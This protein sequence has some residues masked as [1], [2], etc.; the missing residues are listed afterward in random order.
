MLL[1]LP[2]EILLRILSCFSA[3][4]LACT[5]VC[6][7][8]LQA[9]LVPALMQEQRRLGLSLPLSRG[10]FDSATR[11]LRFLKRLASRRPQKLSCGAASSLCV[12]SAH[13]DK[14]EK[15]LV[16]PPGDDDG[17][18]TEDEADAV[19]LA[20]GS[21]SSGEPTA[22]LPSP[23][24]GLSADMV[25]REVAAG[26]SHCLLLTSDGAVLSWGLDNACGQCG[27]GNTTAL[28]TPTP[29]EALRGERIMQVACG[30]E[31]SLVLTSTGVVKSFGGGSLGRLGLGGTDDV[32]TPL[33]VQHTCVRPPLYRWA[34]P[35]PP[36]RT[37]THHLSE[38]VNLP[39]V[40]LVSAGLFH[41]MAV[42]EAGELYSW[43]SGTNGRLGHGDTV[44]QL[45]PRRVEALSDVDVVHASAGSGHSL[46]VSSRGQLFTWGQGYAG[47]LG[48][49]NQET[50]LRP[51]L[52]EALTRECI[53]SAVAGSE[54]TVALTSRGAAYS[55]G[56]GDMTGTV[57]WGR[58]WEGYSLKS[59][60]PVR[61][62][63]LSEV[64]IAGA[65]AGMVRRLHL[66]ADACPPMRALP[67]TLQASLCGWALSA[68]T[69]DP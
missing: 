25:I 65:A 30:R 67:G 24:H 19:L 64:H 9:L 51:Q 29:I 69:P 39:R 31:H 53:T 56:M 32:H 28:A 60:E 41:S 40:T 18:Q 62:K 42:S 7:H 43:G 66:H 34:A 55:F 47:R 44:M 2:E 45:R 26:D 15:N 35:S 58:G 23:V 14:D 17:P 46:A 36:G 54:F 16:H 52:V 33:A 57:W 63:A 8:D 5:T 49:G 61:I 10:P 59:L 21:R 13:G 12:A 6:C 48:H 50:K 1:Q 68:L 37:R 11:R 27:H 20:W 38:G 22:T 3:S 4:T